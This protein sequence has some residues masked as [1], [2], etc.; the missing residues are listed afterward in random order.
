MI[1]PYCFV[2]ISDK[3]EE[4]RIGDDIDGEYTILKRQCFECKRNIYHLKGVN[5][6][7]I[8][9]SGMP[10]VIE[11]SYL[12]K[13]KIIHKPIPPEVQRE[14]SE[15]YFEASIILEDSPKASAALS[16][17]CLQLILREK[18]LVKKGNLSDEIQQVLNSGTLPTYLSDSIDAVR[19]I[20]NFAAHPEKSKSTGEII[21]V[22]PGEAEWNIEVIEMLYDFYFV[23]PQRAREK[24][25]AL[26][27]KLNDAGKPP[28]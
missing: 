7:G 4:I 28:M 2:S 21:P 6:I 23:Q 18:A 26:N 19:N 10:G 11:E 1:C 20:G 9:L 15:D 5:L 24:K 13:P 17:R 25:A 12:I 16:R 3:Y 27:A 14:F 8:G 22:E